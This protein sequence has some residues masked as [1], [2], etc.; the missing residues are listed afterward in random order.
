MEVRSLMP[1]VV[2]PACGNGH[3]VR[4][5]QLGHTVLCPACLTSHVATTGR[6]WLGDLA[7]PHHR[8]GL[9]AGIV[10]GMVAVAF[11][12]IGLQ[13]APALR[14]EPSTAA[15]ASP[16]GLVWLALPFAAAS[17]WLVHRWMQAMRPADPHG[18]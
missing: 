8:A 12:W 18:W 16:K 13:N 6:G 17:A 3:R 2:C 7:W 9:W 5:Q 4:G 15:K 10:L 11:L 14:A 1:P